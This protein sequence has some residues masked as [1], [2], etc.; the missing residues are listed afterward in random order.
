MS[1]FVVLCLLV[2]RRDL[3]F[4]IGR[5]REVLY[6]WL[7]GSLEGVKGGSIRWR[8]IVFIGYY[9]LRLLPESHKFT[10]H[11]SLRR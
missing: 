11:C 5:A 4:S 7:V 6:A 3:F 10:K 8:S 2:K 9:S 1:M